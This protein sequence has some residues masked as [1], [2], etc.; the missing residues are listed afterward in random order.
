MTLNRTPRTI[1]IRFSMTCVVARASLFAAALCCASNNAS[2]QIGEFASYLGGGSDD[3]ARAV[4]VLEDG[5]SLVVGRTTST[6]FPATAGV[7][8]TSCNLGNACPDAFSGG[9]AFVTK[10]AADG[11]TVVFSTYLGGSAGETAHD[12]TVTA[13][14]NIVVVGATFSS[15]FP[16]TPNAFDTSFQGFQQPDGFLTV[17]DPAAT[18][19]LYSTYFGGG[20]QDEIFAIELDAS[21]DFYVA[22]FTSSDDFPTS[23]GAFDS[24]IGGSFDAFVAKFDAS[25]ALAF[26]TYLGGSA[27]EAATSVAVDASGRLIASGSTDSSD[28]PTTLG[29]FD[30]THAGLNEGFV[31]KLD[32]AGSALVFSTLIGGAGSDSVQD[33]GLDSSGRVFAIGST[34]SADFFTSPGSFDS[35]RAF[36]GDAFFTVLSSDGA[37][38]PYSTFLSNSSNSRFTGAALD[39][40][41]GDTGFLLISVSETGGFGDREPSFLQLDPAQDGEN[42]LLYDCRLCYRFSQGNPE[43]LEAI[44]GGLIVV[45]ESDPDGGF[46]VTPGAFDTTHNGSFDGFVIG[47]PLPVIF[48]DGFESGD[49]ASWSNSQP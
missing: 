16:T 44:P 29:A 34:G 45:G 13:S 6:D 42:A 40:G 41:P 9:D 49:L 2:G 8:S 17:L 20:S 38:A 23:I 26:S 30:T 37:S 11:S 14:G 47:A 4:H 35:S 5:T 33:I 15:D 36:N 46:A 25:G 1:K 43:D 10:F 21:G 28:F 31:T 3:S 7:V 48:A 32:T 19:I 27:F 24:T 22:G 12:V 18:Q 39:V